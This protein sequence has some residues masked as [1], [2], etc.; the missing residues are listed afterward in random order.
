M[1]IL[2][3][4]QHAARTIKPSNSS[5]L[6]N[7][8]IDFKQ[9][10]NTI[11]RQALWSH[12][13]RIRMPAILLSDLQSLHA[14]DQYL[15]QDGHKAARVKPT[16]GVKLGSPL[17]PLLFSLYINDIDTIAEGVQGAATGTEDVRVTHMLHADDLTLVANAPDAM[18]TM[19]NRLVVYA[20]SIRLTINTAKSEVVHF[21]S[22]RGAQVPTFMLASAALKCSDSFKCLD[23]TYHQTLNMTASSEHAAIPMLAAAHQIHGFVRDTALCEKPFAS[24]WLATA[25]VVPA[26]MYGCQV[27]S[28]G[29]LRE[30]D[31]LRPTLQTL[32]FNILKGT[33]GVKQSAPNR[34]VLRECAHEPL[35]FYWLRA[36]I[37][38][39]NCLFSS[40]S[41]TLKQAPHADLKMVPRAKTSWASDILRAFEGLQGCDTCTETFSQGLPVYHSDF[42]ADLRFRTRKV[43]RDIADMNPLESDNKL[44]T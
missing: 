14:G 42:T 22:K 24:L 44:V 31:V 12:F 28:S 43:W 40:Y 36:A 17:S 19:L 32:H 23:M 25:Q 10:Y 20:R 37:R 29:F 7:A 1:F 13:R 3:H 16:V 8:F 15:L 9:A 35:Q 21:N 38:F 39:Y 2:R 6:H 26:G 27:W 34:A 30:G 41:A 5:R 11:P 18:Q 33:P 4:L